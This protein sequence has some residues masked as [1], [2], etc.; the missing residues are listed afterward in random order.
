[1]DSEPNVVCPHCNGTD[2][3]VEHLGIPATGTK[4]TFG[5]ALFKKSKLK[6]YACK[7]CGVVS[8]F[9][10]RETSPG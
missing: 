5:S 4:L 8:L 2:F 9:V 7:A 10:E 6:A 3:D 1:M